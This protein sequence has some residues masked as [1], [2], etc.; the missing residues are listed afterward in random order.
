[1]TV[2]VATF[3]AVG[4][5]TRA[6]AYGAGCLRQRSALR[7]LERLLSRDRSTAAD[8]ISQVLNSVHG[9][10]KTRPAPWPKSDVP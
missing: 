3:L 6:M 10:R 5:T 8:D 9:W 2:D 7:C 4:L 1:M